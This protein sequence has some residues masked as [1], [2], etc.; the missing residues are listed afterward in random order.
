L[1]QPMS[2][3]ETMSDNKPA[4]F[5]PHRCSQLS[6]MRTCRICKLLEYLSK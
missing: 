4:Y 5:S 3:Y 2:K 6:S 1:Q